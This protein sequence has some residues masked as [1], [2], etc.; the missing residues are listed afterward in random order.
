M[1]NKKRLKKALPWLV[2]VVLLGSATTWYF[3][4]REKRLKDDQDIDFQKV[5]V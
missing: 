3:V 4:G 2:S 1:K 5:T